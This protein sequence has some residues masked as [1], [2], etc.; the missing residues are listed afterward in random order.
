LALHA[1]CKTALWGYI[2]ALGSTSTVPVDDTLE[3][4][5]QDLLHAASLH[6][7]AHCSSKGL[8]LMCSTPL[9]EATRRSKS[10]KQAREFVAFNTAGLREDSA[11]LA[12]ALRT[13]YHLKH[14]LQVV[15]GKSVRN[16]LLAD[17]VKAAL[18]GDKQLR[19]QVAT[20]TREVLPAGAKALP[21]QVGRVV[22]DGPAILM[23]MCLEQLSAE[24]G[25]SHPGA[26]PSSQKRARGAGRSRSQKRVCVHKPE[27]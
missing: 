17:A 12:H 11:T 16:D 19:L 27:A 21:D 5:F 20:L 8:C 15:H 2:R 23:A 22:P 25:L 18:P 13:H 14:K 7:K 1:T 6:H 10:G 4:S 26:P 3:P 9:A 24:L